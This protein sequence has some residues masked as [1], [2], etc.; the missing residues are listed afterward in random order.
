MKIIILGG[1][2]VA[3]AGVCQAQT[4]Y[5][6]GNTYSQQACSS[7]AK[8][9]PIPAPGS[10]LD[11]HMRFSQY[12][13]DQESKK[14]RIA[15]Q[16][17]EQQSADRKARSERNASFQNKQ[18]ENAIEDYKSQ[19]ISQGKDS[20]LQIEARNKR[21]A[22]SP[23]KIQSNK[24]R[25]ISEIRATL[26]DPQSAIFGSVERTK[27]ANDYTLKPITPSAW[28]LVTVNAKNSFGAFTGMEKKYCAFDLEE[29]NILY[30]R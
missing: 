19:L 3:L 8:A 16:D 15:V 20:T 26:K 17:E 28:Y 24:I 12:C 30:I 18:N 9:I 4:M 21:P 1:L 14:Q 27:P 22:L 6:C 11:E 29:N 13:K 10:C 2:L 7:E 5:R 25:C 23:S